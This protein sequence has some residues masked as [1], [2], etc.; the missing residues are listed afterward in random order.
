MENNLP[1]GW[2]EATLEELCKM[3][4]GK[5]LLT[6][7]LIT[8]GFPVY[9]ANGVI[10]RYNVF[11]Y[12]DPQVI[13]SCRGAASGVIH[14]T[15]SKSFITSNSIVLPLISKEIN[16][17][18]F[19]YTLL[20]VDRSQ[21]VTGSA[22]PQITIDN[23]KK[24]TIP[25]APIPEQH[26]IVAKLESLMQKV[27]SNKKRVD[28]IPVLL[29]RFRQSVL[30]AAISGRLTEDWREGKELMN[31]DRLQ[32]EL[33]KYKNDLFE[34]ELNIWKAYKNSKSQDKEKAIRPTKP[35]VMPAV[36]DCENVSNLEIPKTWKF[37]RFSNV[38][39]KIGDIDH[40]MPKDYPNGIP[41][42]STGDMK[43]VNNLDFINSK[44]I[45]YSD[46]KMLSAKIKP[47]RDDII[48]PRYGTIG[49]NVL[50][51]FDKE[52]LVSYSCAIIKNI[53]NHMDPKYV[54]Y[55]SISPFIKTEISKHVVETTQANIGIASIEKFLFSL[56]SLEEQKEIV[57]RVEQL[58]AFTDKIEAHQTKAKAILDKLPQSILAKAFRGELV[59]QDPND[60]PASVLLERIK[61]QKEKTAKNKLVQGKR[62]TKPK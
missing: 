38:T 1:I 13:I 57:K 48:F 43:D 5:G 62:N 21:I 3:V 27:E 34:Q 30:A 37:V 24:L 17:D 31:I 42:L 19:K 46:Y 29:K 61:A 23:L 60:E 50:I 6:K 20:S 11:I 4:Y 10:G 25:I 55:V 35:K 33:I 36:E 26:R 54:Y 7:Q 40:K 53:K 51:N 47:E 56:C 44:K 41:Y 59:P 39:Y 16:L 2:A 22:Q 9:G 18:F 32:A 28:K 14:K 58:F 8:D 12:E 45:S 49:R 52:F 15:V